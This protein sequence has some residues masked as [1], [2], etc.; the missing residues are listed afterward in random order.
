MARY[1]VVTK[2]GGT[3]TGKLWLFHVD[4]GSGIPLIREPQALVT[5][6]AALTPDGRYIWYAQRQGAWQYNAILPQTQLAMF[7]RETGLVTPMSDRYGSAF[8]PALSPDGRFLAYG[9]RHDAETGIVR[10]RP[11]LG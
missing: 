4:G 2:I 10:A 8:R 1:I 3:P 6:G 9:T 5:L 7:D 11:G